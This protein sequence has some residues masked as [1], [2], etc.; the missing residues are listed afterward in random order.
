MGVLV[1]GEN[2]SKV[3]KMGEVDIYALS[4]VSFEIY[5]SELLVIL[6]PSGSG[7]STLLNI[8]GGMDTLTSGELYYRE[9]ALHKGGRRLLT[10]YRRDAV[11]FVFQFYNLMPNLTAIEN[12]DLAR[13]ISQSPLNAEQMLDSVGLLARKDHFPAQLS[14]GEQQRVAIARA[15]AKNPEILLCDEPTGA[16]DSTSSR[17]VLKILRKFS[18]EFK[19]TVIIITHEASIANMADRVM[20]IRDGKIE[21]IV[22]NENP[23]GADEVVL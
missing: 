8:V 19:K 4:S 2:V 11:G 21:K 12:V 23:I 1:K 7:K 18:T 13:E 6:G 5:D 15:L 17:E 3:Y 22:K 14:G 20:Y 10:E 9:K 16:L